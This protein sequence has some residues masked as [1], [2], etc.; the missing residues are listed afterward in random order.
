MRVRLLVDDGETVAGDEEILSLAAHPSIQVRLY[1]P[2]DYRGHHRWVRGVDFLFHKR[3]LDHR[4][5][6]KL[7][8]V[9]NTL[10]LIGGRNIGDQYFQID[11][12]SQFGDD[13]L[14]VAG[15]MV[16]QLSDVFDE[17][18]NGRRSIPAAAVDRAHTS[19]SALTRYREALGTRQRSSDFQSELLKRAAAG[20]P[21]AG[22]TSGRT[23]LIWA[24]ARLVYDSPDKDRTESGAA[25]KLISA[26]VEEQTG[27]ATSELLMV[28]PYFVPTP[29]EMA[30]LMRERDRHVRVSILTNSLEAA[31]DLVAH[32]GYIHYRMAMLEDGVELH[33]I[34][35]LLGS[36]RG[37]GEGRAIANR[38]N[39][40]L[41][42]KLYVFDRQSVF[43]GSF[44]F[45]Q[46][47][48]R[49]NTEIGLIISSPELAGET[50][51]RF[52]SLTQLK[53]S[54]SLA[55]RDA[56]DGKRPRVVWRTEV[57][58]ETAEYTADPARSAWQ[59]VRLRLLVAAA[60]RQGIVTPANHLSMKAGMMPGTT[61]CWMITMTTSTNVSTML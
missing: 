42:A 50:V 28:T 38:G 33:E 29:K 57:G 13:D 8:V 22:I 51:A 12:G 7:M 32:A 24:Q 47:S 11:P 19:A 60:A 1:N 15:A 14:V 34:R 4:M 18:W 56:G 43:V 36:T 55:L 17:F 48:K 26:A 41:H 30:L 45:D 27:K 53:N 61:Y 3:R 39:Y 40:A 52:D 37:S 21:F 23:P 2:F 44:N 16:R 31:P 25:G 46:R 9:D 54:Y 10:A 20:E 5:H 6:N 58:G 49:L 35:A 59:R